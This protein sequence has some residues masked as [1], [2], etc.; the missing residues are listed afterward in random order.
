MNWKKEEIRLSD[1]RI[2]TAQAPVILSAS[3]STDIPAFYSDW[4]VNR[5]KEGYVKWKNP[6][7]GVPLYISFHKARLMV[8]W[9]KNPK[10][11]FKYLD[12]FDEC[13]PNYYFQYTLNNYDAERLEPCVP[14][15]SE[16]IDTFVALSERIGKEKVIWRFDPLILTDTMGVE[17]LLKKVE[18]V[19]DRLK[20]HTA[21]LVI[22]FADIQTYRKVQANLRRHSVCYK[23]FDEESMLAF[24]SGLHELNQKWRLRIATC[25]EDIS[26]ETYGIEP[27][28]CIDDDLIIRLFSHDKVLMDFL[29]VRIIQRDLFDP[30][31][32]V[33][34]LRNNKDKGQRRLC[35]CIKSKDIGQYN[36]CPHLCLYCYAN[37]S[38]EVVLNNREKHILNRNHETI[39]GE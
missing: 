7:N 19:G 39:E 3:R 27:N 37:A 12:Y 6:F 1:G 35:G 5:M 31:F 10:P 9:S 18:F 16:R 26:L 32:Q 24:S 21:K 15:L 30:T 34:K 2:V 38:Q 23:E 25:A 33:E 4:L 36:T 13:L 29:K 22:S 8:F 17:E 28:K 11:L 20:E 14:D